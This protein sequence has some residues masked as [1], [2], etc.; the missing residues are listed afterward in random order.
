MP[1]NLYFRFLHHIWHGFECKD[2]VPV[3]QVSGE[4]LGVVK[5][6]RDMHERKAE[7]AKHSDAFIALPGHI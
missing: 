6:V 5:V 2:V 1:P 3:F 4:T 7:M